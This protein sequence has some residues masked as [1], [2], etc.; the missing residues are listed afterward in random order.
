MAD[1][2]EKLYELLTTN[3]NKEMTNLNTDTYITITDDE[4]R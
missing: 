1:Y 2:F 4:A 3:E